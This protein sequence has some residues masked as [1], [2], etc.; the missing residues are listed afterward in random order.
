MQLGVNSQR[1]GDL[2]VRL[3][4]GLQIEVVSRSEA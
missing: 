4:G 3:W 2:E 1:R